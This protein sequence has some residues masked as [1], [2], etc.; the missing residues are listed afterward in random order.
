M[1]RR[2]FVVHG[3]TNGSGQ[4]M[5]TNRDEMEDFFK[6]WPDSSFVMSI[7]LVKSKPLST[8]LLMYYK[9]KIVPDMQRAFYDAGEWMTPQTVDNRLRSWSGITNRMAYDFEAR[10]WLGEIKDLEDLDNQ[11]LVF[12]IEWV[13]YLASEQYGVYFEDPHP[14]VFVSPEFDDLNNFLNKI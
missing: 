2:E 5:I 4:F 13:K 8:P 10:E 14:T 6:K 11:E 7:D 1:K 9:R 3:R 12:F